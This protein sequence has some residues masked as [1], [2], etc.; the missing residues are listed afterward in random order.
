[1]RCCPQAFDN[2][3]DAAAAAA[4]PD[5]VAIDDRD[6]FGPLSEADEPA[7]DRLSGELSDTTDRSES[8][9]AESSSDGKDFVHFAV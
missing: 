4:G 2:L 8:V 9:L 3:G 6:E 5:K 1:M 7:E